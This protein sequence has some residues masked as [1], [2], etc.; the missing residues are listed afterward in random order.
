M[1]RLATR[2]DIPAILN[3]YAPY[4]RETAFTFE[5]EVPEISD[6]EARF[7]LITARFPWLVWEENGRIL[8]YAYGDAAFSRKAFSWD[9]DM[10]IYLDMSV[11]GQGIGG[12]LYG[13]LEQMLKNLGYCNLY[14]LV[15]E[16]NQASERFH[17]GR[18]YEVEG[19]LKKSGFKFGRWHGLVWY[20]LRVREPENPGEVPAAFACTEEAAALMALYSKEG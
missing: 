1:I 8:G 13:C 9:A 11:R 20:V 19:L 7:D 2:A 5:Y 6:F 16:G 18:G 3:I 17:E 4:I 15:T 10:S 14:A 12:K